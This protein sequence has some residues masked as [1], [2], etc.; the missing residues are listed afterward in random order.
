MTHTKSL[1]DLMAAMKTE[2]AREGYFRDKKPL[3]KGRIGNF[4]EEILD[5]MRSGSDTVS[6]ELSQTPEIQLQYDP[7]E[8]EDN[9]EGS[10][11]QIT[12]SED[13]MDFGKPL[14]ENNSMLTS[15]LE[16]DAFQ[17]ELSDIIGKQ[18]SKNKKDRIELFYKK[19]KGLSDVIKN[20]ATTEKPVTSLVKTIIS[21]YRNIGIKELT[22]ELRQEIN[23]IAK[24]FL[25]YAKG[26]II[27]YRNNILSFKSSLTEQLEDLSAIGTK[28][29]K[30][31]ERSIYNQTISYIASKGTIPTQNPFSEISSIVLRFYIE[32]GHSI[33][34]YEVKNITRWV[35]QFRTRYD[36]NDIISLEDRLQ[37]N[38]RPKSARDRSKFVYERVVN[39]LK[40][41]NGKERLNFFRSTYKQLKTDFKV[42]Y[43][44]LI[45]PS[46]E[47]ETDTI[48]KYFAKYVRQKRVSVVLKDLLSIFNSKKDYHFSEDTFRQ[49]KEHAINLYKK[50]GLPLI[51]NEINYIA[52]SLNSSLSKKYSGLQL[53]N[54][55]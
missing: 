10:S 13:D 39:Y 4:T 15:I 37:L 2:A 22:E 1:P 40:S 49:L 47:G 41:L 36:G 18:I 50:Y 19:V 7:P 38:P 44:R 20:L 45:L 9:L 16:D 51:Q 42:L 48:A 25:N 46:I 21:F 53:G 12:I 14:L 27:S 28:A 23:F 43:N 24:T 26:K 52:N 35:L 54:V 30:D 55:H 11:P 29:R 33:K 5:T 17:Q 34:Q 6:E 8:P 31:R 3:H 32:G